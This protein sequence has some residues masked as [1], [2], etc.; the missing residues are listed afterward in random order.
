MPGNALCSASASTLVDDG[1]S[2]IVQ[3]CE[4][5]VRC[6]CKSG[7]SS[8][9]RCAPVLFL[10]RACP[11]RT[12]PAAHVGQV[13]GQAGLRTAKPDQD[14]GSYYIIYRA[15]RP[16]CPAGQQSQIRIRINFIFSNPSQ[17][18]IKLTRMRRRLTACL[19]S[20]AWVSISE[21]ALCCVQGSRKR[22][23][24]VVLAP[25]SAQVV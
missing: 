15:G 11:Q 12:Y 16:A 25:A 2:R 9:W 8:H 6:T 4:L 3:R 14:I 18:Q 10:L 19:R 17:G 24:C 20:A 7:P 23:R 21:T 1:L 13:R 5:Q 22:C